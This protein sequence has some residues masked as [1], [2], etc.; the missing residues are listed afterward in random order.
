MIYSFSFK[1]H[2]RNQESCCLWRTATAILEGYWSNHNWKLMALTTNFFYNCLIFL[3][4]W[5]VHVSV[6][7][8]AEY[9]PSIDLSN[10]T[11]AGIY[12]LTCVYIPI[13]QHVGWYSGSLSTNIDRES[14]N[15]PPV[16]SDWCISRCMAHHKIH[17]PKQVLP[18]FWRLFVLF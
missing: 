5:Q 18:S 3:F 8:S 2:S 9:P 4:F 15:T 17:D 10:N 16:Y 1:N 13:S 7:I 11:S 6:D 14:I 12:W